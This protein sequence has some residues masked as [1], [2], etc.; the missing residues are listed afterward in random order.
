MHEGLLYPIPIP[1]KKAGG[2]RSQRWLHGQMTR[3]HIELSIYKLFR[4]DNCIELHGPFTRATHGDSTQKRLYDA[5]ATSTV[6]KHEASHHVS[7]KALW[8]TM[9]THLIAFV[10]EPLSDTN[11]CNCF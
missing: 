1:F 4:H 7:I 3:A 5:H 6:V 2:H 10:W 11:D 8:N 9:I